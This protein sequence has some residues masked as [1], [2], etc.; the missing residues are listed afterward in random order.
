MD[1]EPPQQ[2]AYVPS[3]AAPAAPAGQQKFF[4]DPSSLLYSN[5]DFD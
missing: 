3:P 1:D 2:Q 4:D 5:K